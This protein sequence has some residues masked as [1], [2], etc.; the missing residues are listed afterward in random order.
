[1]RLQIDKQSP[2]LITLSLGMKGPEALLPS[3]AL[4]ILRR[5]TAHAIALPSGRQLSGA[6]AQQL[7]TTACY[8]SINWL[9][10]L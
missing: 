2:P 6:Q 1:M 3:A 4:G 10:S 8:S 5:Q 7:R 9:V